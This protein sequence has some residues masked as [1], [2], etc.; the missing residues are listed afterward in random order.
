MKTA[1]WAHATHTRENVLK[2]ECLLK[3]DNSSLIVV[4]HC[5]LASAFLLMV[6]D[7]KQ[8]MTAVL[9]AAT[10]LQTPVLITSKF[11]QIKILIRIP[12]SRTAKLM[13]I[14]I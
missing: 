11:A 14:Q 8:M 13:A 7:V 4:N 12:I 3:R 9:G 10:G 6:A 2:S 1:V 5:N